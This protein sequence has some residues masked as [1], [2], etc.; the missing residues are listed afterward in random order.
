MT[1]LAEKCGIL[2]ADNAYK[3]QT[4]FLN[5]EAGPLQNSAQT[6]KSMPVIVGLK[7]DNPNLRFQKHL[8]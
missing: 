7:S 6:P 5:P 4:M 8:K 1:R 3:H 2:K